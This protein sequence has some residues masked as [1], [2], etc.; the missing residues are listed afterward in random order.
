MNRAASLNGENVHPGSPAHKPEKV[1]VEQLQRQLV[2]QGYPAD[3][4]A[5]FLET[6]DAVI[7][8]RL[9]PI[10]EQLQAPKKPRRARRLQRQLVTLDQISAIVQKSK[11]TMERWR[12]HMPAPAVAGRRNFPSR[13]DWRVIRPW[14][15][16][17]FYMLLPE[18]YPEY[19]E[20]EVEE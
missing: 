6:V 9:A 1:S 19:W 15:M 20:A 7:S 4:L 18:R 2:A 5:D 8:A 16:D 3:F 13:W 11:R 17:H 12:K 14:L 10:V